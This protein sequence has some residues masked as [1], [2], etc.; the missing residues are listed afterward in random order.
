VRRLRSSDLER[1]RVPLA[2]VLPFVELDDHRPG[3]ALE[4]DAMRRL[5]S[6]VTGSLDG[7]LLPRLVTGAAAPRQATLFDELGAAPTPG[8]R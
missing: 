7:E 6:G 4:S 5:A 1:L 8:A 3:K 2:K